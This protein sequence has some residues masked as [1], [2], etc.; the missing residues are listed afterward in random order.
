MGAWSSPNQSISFAAPTQATTTACNLQ[1]G[2]N[3]LVWTING[4]A[5]GQYAVDT[6]IVDY[7][8]LTA[9]NDETNI[10]F[11]GSGFVNVLFN[12]NIQGPASVTIDQEPEHGTVKIGSSGTLTYDADINFVGV[13]S[14]IYKVCQEGCACAFATV[15]FNVGE[16]AKCEVPTIITPNHDGMNDAFVIPCLAEDGAYLNNVVSIFNQW[17]DEV[18][19]AEPYKNNWQGTF[20]GEDLPPST[21]FYILDLGNGEKPMSGYLIIQR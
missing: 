14:A 16:D 8:V 13:D 19:H 17:G 6:V 9:T 12:D 20:D 1:V 2:E 18:Y 7:M 11:A 5:C 21:Y 10:P 3:I 15:Y 4:G